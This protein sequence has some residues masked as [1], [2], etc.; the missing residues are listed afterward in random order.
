M[1]SQVGPFRLKHEALY[2][3]LGERKRPG[4]EVSAQRADAPAFRPGR[5]QV[6][7]RR[8]PFR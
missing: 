6:E 8:P 7:T 4:E 3:T 2:R 1:E 5:R